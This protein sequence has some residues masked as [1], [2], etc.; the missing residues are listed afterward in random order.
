M[1][2]LTQKELK[3]ID[4]TRQILNETALT[5]EQIMDKMI[6]TIDKAYTASVLM[7]QLCKT[8]DLIPN[9][10][11]HHQFVQTFSNLQ[12]TRSEYEK[13]LQE[14]Y[15]STL[16]LEKEKRKRRTKEEMRDTIEE[17]RIIRES[18]G[19]IPEKTDT[20]VNGDYK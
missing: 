1:K 5:Q 2:P 16:P 9:Q 4:E 8:M 12:K 10:T 14:M 17:E 13:D 7:S 6:K 19:D 20:F 18:I 3:E 15:V 11:T